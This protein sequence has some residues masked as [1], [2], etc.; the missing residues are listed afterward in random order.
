[1][2]AAAQNLHA[3]EKKAASVR[4]HELIISIVND[5]GRFVAGS[6]TFCVVFTSA[7]DAS[8]V[9]VKDVSVEFAQQVGRILEGPTHAQI[10][11]GNAER[12]YGK[13]DL[14]TQYYQPAF[15]YVFIHYTDVDGKR[16]KCR[17]SL[18]VRA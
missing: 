8:P 6:N 11:E 3:S 15:H 17:L 13:V 18:S 4:S 12:F 16:R 9:L 10:T 14:G 1:L 5:S 7:A 2:L